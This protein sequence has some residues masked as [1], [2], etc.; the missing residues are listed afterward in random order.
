MSH[1]TGGQKTKHRRRNKRKTKRK[2]KRKQITKNLKDEIEGI[3]LKHNE[4]N[5]YDDEIEE[6]FASVE[7]HREALAKVIKDLT[8]LIEQEKERAVMGFIDYMYG[9]NLPL[10]KAGVVTVRAF[11]KQYLA[12]R[13]G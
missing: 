3:L 9:Q 12:E 13:K 4:W 5:A 1:R 11:A 2:R 7:Y 10:H 6:G 8:S